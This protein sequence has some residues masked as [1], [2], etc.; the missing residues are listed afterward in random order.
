MG[1]ITAVSGDFA[2]DLVNFKDLDCF[3]VLNLS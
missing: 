3:A 2:T 1:R